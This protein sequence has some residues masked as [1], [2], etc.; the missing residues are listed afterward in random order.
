M[1]TSRSSGQLSVGTTTISSYTNYIS[2]VEVI[3]DGT[4]VGVITLYD[5]ADGSGL[6]AG[7][8]LVVVRNKTNLGSESVHF[9]NPIR[10]QNGITAVVSGTG[11]TAVVWLGGAM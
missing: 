11:A 8:T 10:A 9:T 4:N 3:S 2:G 6:T 5:S 7:N 1:S